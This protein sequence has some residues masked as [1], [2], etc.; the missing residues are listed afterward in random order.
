VLAASGAGNCL[1]IPTRAGP[2]VSDPLPQFV[3]MRGGG[4]FVLPGRR[5]LAYLAGAGG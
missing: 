5:L 4:N 3:T 1:T 2:V